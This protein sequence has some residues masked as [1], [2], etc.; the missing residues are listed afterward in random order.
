M[1]ILDLCCGLKGASEPMKR[2]GWEVITLDNNPTFSPDIVAD[3]TRWSYQG[4]TPDLVWASP[5]CDEFSR[6]FMPWSRTSNPPDLSIYEAC[7]RIIA[8][9][10]PSFW[11]I[12]NTRGAVP[13]FGKPSAIYYP[14]YLWGFFPPLGKINLAERRHKESYPSTNKAARAMIPP[15]L[16]LRV[17]QVIESQPR[18]FPSQR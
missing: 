18:L 6:E 3:I 7:K 16:S 1:L 17:A 11:I 14:Y 4:E 2:R 12:E 15:A 8:E 5:P 9:T 10:Q 13:Y